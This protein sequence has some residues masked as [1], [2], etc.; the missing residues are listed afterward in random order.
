M[1]THNNPFGWAEPPFTSSNA[2]LDPHLFAPR[3]GAHVVASSHDGVQAPQIPACSHP[4]AV[5]AAR[6]WLPLEGLDPAPQDL[7][8]TDKCGF[9]KRKQIPPL[10]SLFSPN[11]LSL[12]SVGVFTFDKKP[13]LKC[14]SGRRSGI[15][16]II[17]SQESQV[18]ISV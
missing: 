17:I 13:S 14:C 4:C 3:G 8:R 15:W 11:A 2:L 7:P 12:L 10:G 9:S 5:P 1:S 6:P 16:V 18:L